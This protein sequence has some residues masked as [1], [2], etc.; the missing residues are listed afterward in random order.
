MVVDLSERKAMLIIPGLALETRVR[1]HPEME[2]DAVVR[3]EVQE[4]DL[5]D[6][7]LRLKII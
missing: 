7:D 2:L 3:V 6:Q 5:A 1:R 4:I